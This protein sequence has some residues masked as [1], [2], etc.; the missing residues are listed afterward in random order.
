MPSHVYTEPED[1]ARNYLKRI[2]RDGVS[3]RGKKVL[4]VGC[5]T[6]VYSKLMLEFGAT[7]VTG[8]DIE[9]EN[10]SLA[11]RNFEE[12]SLHFECIP[13]LDYKASSKFDFIFARGVVYYFADLASFFESIRRL[14][15]PEGEAVV[16][17]IEKTGASIISNYIKMICCKMPP[18]CHPITV[19]MLSWIYYIYVRLVSRD[20][21]L[22]SVIKE[23]MST[24]FFPA[25]HLFTYNEAF[26][27]VKKHKLS[28]LNTF[29]REVGTDFS[30]YLKLR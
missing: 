30:L 18:A 24:V 17:F 22:F 16:S 13:L 11:R 9:P 25:F 23:K 8:I 2:Q 15:A 29:P 7:E 6:G 21:A 14:S 19:N 26:E 10:I 3:F 12:E 27:I 5:G 1:R 4:D 20:H 28:V